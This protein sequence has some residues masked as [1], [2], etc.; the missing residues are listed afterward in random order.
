MEDFSFKAYLDAW[1]SHDGSEVVALMADDVVFEDV[2]M[3]VRCEGKKAVAALV[4]EMAQAS[5]DF[6]FEFVTEIRA[7]SGYAGEW[8][9]SGTNTG[10]GAGLPATGKSFTIRGLSIGH[11][12]P[13]GRILGNRDY[14]NMAELLTQVGLL[15][16]PG[17]SPT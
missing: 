13:D 14:W 1:S 5:D 15:P 4:A 12:A 10:E 3:G 16:P 17:S 2:P 11:L 6:R 7:G 9:L 8:V